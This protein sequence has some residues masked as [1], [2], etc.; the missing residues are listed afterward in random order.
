MK[1]IHY[2]IGVLILLLTG[3]PALSQQKDSLRYPIN[4]RRGDPFSVQSKNPFDIRDTSLIK[5]NI[6]YDPKTKQYYIIEKIGSSYYR[7]PTTLSFDEFW[8]I[9]AKQSETDYFKKRADALT[10]L[11]KKGQRPFLRV[12]DQLFDRIFGLNN[13]SAPGIDQVKQKIGEVKSAVTDLKKSSEDLKKLNKM[14]IDI[15]PTGEVNITAGYQGQNIENP[16]LPELARKNGGFDFDMNAKLNV[17]ANIGDKLKFPINY[18]TLSNFGFDNQIKLDYKGMKDEIL[19]SLEAGNISFQSRSVL[20][21]SAQNLFGVKTQLQFGKLFITGAIAN[22]R[23]SRQSVGLQGGASTQNFSKKLDD[24]EE[25]RHFLVGQYFRNN[26]NKT[27]SSLPVVNTQVQIQRMEVWVTNRTGATT[28]ARD[29]VGLMDLGESKPYNPAVSS[30]TTNPLPANG[31]NNLYSSLVSNPNARNPTLINSLLLNKGLKPVDDYEKTFARKLNPTEYYYNPKVGFVSINVQL[32]ADEVLAIAYQYTYNGKVYQVGEFSQDVALDSTRGIQKVLFLKLLKAT[33]QRTELPTWGWMMKNVYSLDLFGGI[34]QEDFKLNV[35]YEEPSGGL[36]RYLPESSPAVDG[37]PLLRIL[38]L[39]RLNNRNDPQPDGVFD[40]IDG[41]TILPIMGRVIFPVLEPFGRDLDTLAFAGQS[42]AIKNKYVYNQLYDSIKAIAQT[43]ANLN[44]FVMQGQVKGSAGGSEIP[45]NAFNVPPGSVT[46]TAGGL[47]LKEGTDYIVD[48]NLGSV[49]IINAGI[50]SSNAAVKVSFEN[51]A[52][53]GVQQRNFTGLRLDYL[54]N[55]KLTLGSS[56]VRLAERPFFTK[57]GFGEDPIQNAMYGVDFSYKSEFPALTRLLDKLPFYSTKVKS[58]IN[59]YGEGA[60]LQPGHPQQIGKGEQ[61]LIFLDDFEGTRTSIDIRFPF[62]SWALASTPAGNPKFPEST[63]NDSIDY[64][65]NR[66]KLAWYNVE[67]NLQDRG[68]PNNPLKNNLAELSDPRVRQVYTNELFPQRTTNITDVQASTFDLAYYPTD[69][70]P[71]NF[72]SSPSQINA[73]GKLLRPASRWGGIM[74]S[75]DQTDFETSNVEF[76]DFWVQDP[77][78][79]NPNSK[80]G[81]ML[82]NFGNVSEDVLKDGRRFYEN[83]INTPNIPTDIDSSNTWGKTPIN[84]IQITQAFSNNP[85]DRPFQDVG[86]DGLE[87]DGERRKKG[88]VLQKLANNFGQ[89]SSIFQKALIDPSNDDYSWYRDTKFDVL[90]TGILGRYKDFNNPQGN[91]P[92]SNNNSQFTNAATLYPDNEDLNRDNTLN[93]TESYYEYEIQLK[94]GMDVGNTPYI[95][96]KKRVTVNSADGIRRTENWFLFRVPIKSYTRKVGNIPDFKSIRFARM[97]LTDFED[98]VVLRLARLELVRNQWRQFIYNI[99]TTGSYTPINNAGGTIFNTL[100]VNL[101]ENSSRQPVNYLMPPGVERVQQLSNNGVNLQQNEQALSLRVSNLLTGD[102]R[103]V[104]KTMNININQYGRMSMYIHAESIVGQRPLKDNEIYAVIRLGQDFLNNYYEIK[105]PLKV[106]PPGIYLRGQEESVWPIANNLDFNLAELIN[107]KQR[108]NLAG[109]SVSKIYRDV[110]DNKIISIMGN[111]NISQVRGGLIG[112]ENPLKQDGAIV[113]AEVWV[114]ELRLSELDERSAWAAQGRVDVNL[115]DLGTLSVSANTHSTGFGTI[116]QRVNERT[117]EKLWQFDIAGNIDAGK[118][119]PKNARLSFPIYASYNSTVLT[120]EYDPYDGD[121][122]YKEKLNNSPKEKQDS[123]RKSAVDERIVKS[124]SF[125]NVKVQPGAKKPGLLRL[126]NFDF[127][128]AYSKATHNSP[129]ISENSLTKHRGGFGYVFTGEAKY[130]E[131]FKKLIGTKTSWLALIRDVN[132]NLKPSFIGYRADINRQFGEFV[133]RIVNTIDSKVE[134]VDTTYDKFYTFDRFYNLRWDLARSVNF[135]FSAINNARIDEPN[136]RIDTRA[137]KDTV[138]EN[139][140]SG[141]RNTMYQQKAAINYNIPLNKL[142]LTDWITARYSYG[143]SYNWVGASRIALSLGNIIENS[144]E[145]N[146]NAQFNFTSLYNKSK[147]LRAIEDIPPPKPKPDPSKP[148]TPKNV[149]KKD[150]SALGSVIKTKAEVVK[151]LKGKKRKE[152][153]KKWRQQKKD[154]RNA[155]KIGKENEPVELNDATR[156]VGKIVT[157]LKNVSVNYAENYRSRIPGYMDSTK[158]LG[159]NFQSMAPGLDYTFGKQPD[160]NWLNQQAEK[161]LMSRDSTF[162]FLYRQ[163]FEQRFGITAQLEPFREFRIDINLDKSFTKEYS[164]LFK[165]TTGNSGLRHLSPAAMGGFSISYISFGTLFGPN[166]PNQISETFRTFENNR[167]II[168]KR[169]AEGN[170]YWQGLPAGSKFAADGYATGYGRYAQDVLVPAFIAA[171]TG[172]DPKGIPLIDQSN[173]SISSNP[174]AGL[175][176]RP[177]W[178]MTFTGLTKIPSV[179]KTFNNITITHGY[180]GTLSM[181]SFNS[182]LLYQDPFRFNA[183]GFIDTVSGNYIPFF[184]VPNITMQEKFEPLIGIDITTNDQ[185]N[186]KFEYRK[187]RLLTLSLIDYQ[188]SESNATE[189]IIGGSWRTKGFNLPFKL[190]GAKSKTLEND[191]TFRFDMSTRDV[192]NSNSRLDQSNAYG[193]GG[194]KEIS[195]APSIDYVINNRINIK[196]FFD[197]RRVIPYISTSAPITNTRAGLAIRVSLAQ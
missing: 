153:L 95:T 42:Q 32:Q 105:V 62:V 167:L 107:L 66:A 148:A 161:G 39:D 5:R 120:P 68:S 184:L 89:G 26:Y 127:S 194:Q 144:Q 6:E 78:I 51:N 79:K 169:V 10:T 166:N 90:G 160:T 63:L 173:K 128:Y 138:R 47:V 182:A 46:V 41:Y 171:Y 86:F 34:Q 110:L 125:T 152:A 84:P 165:D 40:Y 146:L 17:N 53:F 83:G 174:F 179:A 135:D 112:I 75:I 44:R 77:F 126:S 190:P 134:R 91:S 145:N 29:I 28:D 196:L 100:A 88:Y 117:R 178:K 111:P 118:L 175:I 9:S 12:Y 177:N 93:E 57:M 162:N 109:A 154:A 103:G 136:G 116:E 99:D 59:A 19:K 101:E 87:N 133:P 65:F 115:A 69:K 123:I 157:M 1:A 188:L 94:P 38:N 108:R 131:P 20:I 140:L 185:L 80:G 11:N 159:Q 113:N 139:L 58:S 15:R 170:L 49:K 67:P 176:P 181:N 92:I 85:S 141:G 82:L 2:F 16:T 13:I 55:K 191:L 54:A 143:T 122:R 96:D 43:Y 98:S 33:S 27:M 81:K 70:G 22:Q 147:F 124:I 72:E 189:W 149:S 30:L 25:N 64:N 56:Y 74:R 195:I 23:S 52:G 71:Y 156:A 76:V 45:L 18:N 61:G 3:T 129:V 7:K 50:L 48:Y 121:V 142:P 36:K 31:V 119:V 151:G 60:L 158:F 14:K 102:S 37:K 197:Q 114:N 104:F 97:Y 24:Y 164:E 193:T 4:D 183:P 132:F 137:K 186:L 155:E 172:R 8:K 106:T 163:N 187:S 21:P 35:L 180:N 192:S 168:S 150:T 73:N 130:I